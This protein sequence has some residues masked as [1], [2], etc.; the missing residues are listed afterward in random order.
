MQTATL[1]EASPS[2]SN[3]Y[4]FTVDHRT[5]GYIESVR[6]CID[7]RVKEAESEIAQ[8][9]RII[10]RLSDELGLSNRHKSEYAENVTKATLALAAALGHVL[11]I[12]EISTEMKEWIGLSEDDCLDEAQSSNTTCQLVR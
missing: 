11:E 3:D 7:S 10:H 6:E 4:E 2:N 5:H 8:V 1:S 12:G 9:I